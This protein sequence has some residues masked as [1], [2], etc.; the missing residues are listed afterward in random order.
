MRKFFLNYI[1]AKYELTGDVSQADLNKSIN[2]LRTRVGMSPLLKQIK[3][4]PNAID[5]GYA[6]SPLLYEIRRGRRLELAAEGFRFR[7]IMRWK[8]GKLIEGVETFRAMKL[9]AALRSKYDE[10]VSNIEVDHN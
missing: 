6:V 2:L 4:G 3:A 5:Y 1:E 8:A 7:D 10:D 9:T